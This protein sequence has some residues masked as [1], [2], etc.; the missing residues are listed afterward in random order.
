MEKRKERGLNSAGP[1]AAQTAQDQGKTRARPL[2]R[3]CEKALG[4]LN[5]WERRYVTV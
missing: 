2:W 4:L 1:E 5:N 3:L